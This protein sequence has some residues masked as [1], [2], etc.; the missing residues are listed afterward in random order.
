[1]LVYLGL[2]ILFI[3]FI[4]SV[5]SREEFEND[6]DC[7]CAF[8]LD[9]TLTCGLASAKKAV[10]K[11]KEK[12]CKFAVNTAR[13]VPYYNDIR[14]NEIDLE[15]E[16]FINDIYVWKNNNM[17]FTS[18]DN[19]AKNVADTKVLHLENLATKYNVSKNRIILFD[20]NSTNIEIASKSGFSTIHANDVQCGLPSNVDKKIEYILEN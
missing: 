2:V 13:S 19:L 16:L 9:D 3:L 7:I 12:K 1:M 15:P 18:Y 20:D 11:C 17:T 8:D 14:L 5:I 10:M 4:I 6:V